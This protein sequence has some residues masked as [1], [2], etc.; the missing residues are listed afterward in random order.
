MASE[1]VLVKFKKEIVIICAYIITK[2]Y[3]PLE[4]K[5]VEEPLI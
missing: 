3:L 5:L 1:S 4:R 2:V